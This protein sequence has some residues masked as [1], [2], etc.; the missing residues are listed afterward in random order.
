MRC[1]DAGDLGRWEQPKVQR[2]IDGVEVEPLRIEDP[3]DP[4]EHVLVLL[5][6]GIFDG[7]EKLLATS[8]ATDIV[9]RGCPRAAGAHRIVPLGLGLA[10]GLTATRWHQLSPRSCS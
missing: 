4:D 2:P 5:V 6:P 8:W 9:G 10:S 7:G 3:A 1:T